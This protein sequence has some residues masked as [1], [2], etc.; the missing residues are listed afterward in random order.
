[1]SQID[2]LYRLQQ[3]DDEIN[4]KK[5]QLGEVLRA[6]K[7]N[8][9][10]EQARQRAAAANDEWQQRQTRQTDLNLEL[11]G[12]ADKA[13]RSEDRLY[14]G[15]VKNPKELADLQHEIDSLGRRR[16]QLEDEILEVMIALEE[17]EEE[18]A[19]ADEA[20]QRI[21]AEWRTTLATLQ[22]RQTELAQRI[23]QLNGRREE[24]LKLIQPDAL[25]KYEETS[26]RRGGVA[27]VGLKGNVCQGCQVSVSANIAL[28]AEQRQLAHCGSCGRLLIPV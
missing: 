7:G 13:K 1:M 23:N 4:L 16:A 11:K 15:Q 26:R 25:A 8:Q 14:S 10:L 12:L 24:Q 3:I 21:E 28:A 17:A 5:K 2:L 20:L 22:E 9:T 19:A 27:V 6:Q 18:K